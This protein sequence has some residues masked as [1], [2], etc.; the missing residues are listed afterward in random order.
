[1]RGAG[2][3]RSTFDG[4]VVVYDSVT[5]FSQG[6]AAALLVSVLAGDDRG[7]KTS[8][9]AVNEQPRPPVR[10]PHLPAGFGNRA[11]LVDQFH[12]LDLAWPNRTT[13]VEIDAQSQPRHGLAD[14]LTS[15]TTGE[16][17]SA[18]LL[19]VHFGTAADG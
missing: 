14:G 5:E 17:A 2:F 12:Q 18:L 6:R 9:Q 8:V 3:Y 15:A 1:V 7:A 16:V 11:M 10:H 4:T 19:R 13:P